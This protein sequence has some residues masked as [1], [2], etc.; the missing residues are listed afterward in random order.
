ML[1]R[2]F[3][4][5]KSSDPEDRSTD[6]ALRTSHVVSV[7]MYLSRDRSTA[8][9]ASGRR[10]GAIRWRAE[11]AG[12]RLASAVADA[13]APGPG[14]CAAARA[15]RDAGVAAGLPEAGRV[16]EDAAVAVVRLVVAA[17]PA[18]GAEAGLLVEAG[19]GPGAAGLAVAVAARPGAEARHPGL[20]Q[21]GTRPNRPRNCRTPCQSPSRGGGRWLRSANRNRLKRPSTRRR[22][23]PSSIRA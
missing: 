4:P 20:A 13:G 11:M 14:C 17:C 10:V 5:P 6:P 7:L 21:S 1:R 8:A 18:V 16:P 3:T 23:L 9:L 2:W 19:V 22:N 12:V 15:A